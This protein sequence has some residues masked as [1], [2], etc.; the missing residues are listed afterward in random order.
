MSIQQ[1]SENNFSDAM[2]YLR[3]AKNC[4]KNNRVLEAKK[5]VK[6]ALELDNGNSCLLKVHQQLSSVPDDGFGEVN[7]LRKNNPITNR[8]ENKS[9][10]VMKPCY[11]SQDDA[12]SSYSQWGQDIIADVFFRYNRPRT[13]QFV[14]VGAFDG[15]WLS[16]TRRLF[17]LG[18]S[19]VCIEPVSVA[20]KMLEELYKGTDVKCVQRAISLKEGIVTISDQ[21]VASS[22]Y[23]NMDGRTERVLS[24]KLSTVLDELNVGEIDYLSIDVEGTDFDVLK[25]LD[26]DR[27]HP[28]LVEVEYASTWPE[29]K[30][31]C[32]F[33]EERG[34]ILWLDFNELTF[35]SNDTVLPPE[36]KVRYLRWGERAREDEFLERMVP[37]DEDYHRE[38]VLNAQCR[39]EEM[40]KQEKNQ[41]TMMAQVVRKAL[42]DRPTSFSGS[43][44]FNF[45]RGKIIGANINQQ[46]HFVQK[47]ASVN[48]QR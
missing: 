48:F 7:F 28:Q 10:Y 26:F 17:E 2:F 1:K 39:E 37:M 24:S 33:M 25:N 31:V 19:G 11:I 18:W 14:D 32:D 6:N 20:Y 34:Y 9:G 36:R 23:G 42:T 46:P 15:L 30:P 45:E 40:M 35:R 16:N 13:K 3:E 44:I 4:L 8:C 22:L 12:Y 43:V 47:L 29:R 38:C 41:L 27:Y 21:G 5:Y